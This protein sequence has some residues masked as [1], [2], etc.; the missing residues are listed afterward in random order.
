MRPPSYSCVVSDDAQARTGVSTGA[1][2]AIAIVVMNVATYGLTVAAARLMGPAGFGEFSAV[3]GILMV[4]N[5]LALGLQATGARRVAVAG[6]RARVESEIWRAA[7]RGALLL[8]VVTLL[9]APALKAV[10]DLDSWLSV[11]G[12]AVAAGVLTMVGAL[13]GLLQGEARWWPLAAV[14]VAIGVAR[15]ALGVAALALQPSTAAAMVGVAVGTVVPFVIAWASLSRRAPTPAR[16]SG[17]HDAHGRGVLAELGHSTHA[18]LAFF[19]LSNI[20]IVIAR[21]VLPEY[22]AGLFAGGLIVTK[23]VTF[24]PQFVI[25]LA[26]PVMSRR[27]TSDR[28]HVVGLALVTAIGI[29]ATIGVLLFPALAQ[30]FI[31]GAP[32]AEISASLWLFALAGTALAGT[33]FLVYSSLALEHPRAV[34]V[35]WAGAAFFAAVGLT[36]QTPTILIVDRVWTALATAA[37]LAVVLTGRKSPRLSVRRRARSDRPRR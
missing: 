22:A 10:L 28:A 24:L 19:V 6:D 31:G 11:L 16:R 18:L 13:A 27:G 8:A 14:F 1:A 20:D 26:F 5:V 15:F 33:Q 3:M 21:A 12:L 23:A 4:L 36:A 9:A 25:V 35:L 34:Y 2:V 30:L 17:E 29:S 32:Y 7:T 37:M